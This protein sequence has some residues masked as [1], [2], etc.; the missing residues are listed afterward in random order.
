[1]AELGQ[2]ES[3]EPNHSPF[4]EQVEVTERRDLTAEW[5]EEAE[6]LPK[7]IRRRNAK[8]LASILVAFGILMIYLKC[9]GWW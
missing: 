3:I 7:S 4:R 8:E 6:G 1:M 5:F 9:K 2:T